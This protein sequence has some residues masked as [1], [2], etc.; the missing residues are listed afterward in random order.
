MDEYADSRREAPPEPPKVPEDLLREGDNAYCC[1]N[2]GTLSGLHDAN[3]VAVQLL[4]NSI[5][6]TGSV[7]RS[8]RAF[9]ISGLPDCAGADQ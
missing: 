1:E 2:I 7:D 5:L 9:S 8:L 4:D 6:L 3:I